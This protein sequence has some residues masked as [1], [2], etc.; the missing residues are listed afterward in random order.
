VDRRAFF[1]GVLLSLPF[2][3]SVALLCTTSGADGL[4]RPL[5]VAT[6]SALFAVML[7][8]QVGCGIRAFRGAPLARPLAACTAAYMAGVFAIMLAGDV[9]VRLVKPEFLPAGVARTVV[10][11]AEVLAPMAGLAGLSA[12]TV[13]VGVGA[14]RARLRTG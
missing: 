3:V 5:S 8:F 7:A 14:A 6:M 11:W 9:V 1:A 4:Y 10:L 2:T 13:G 12:V